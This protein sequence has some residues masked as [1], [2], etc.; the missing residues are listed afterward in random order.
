ME[1]EINLNLNPVAIN[2]TTTVFRKVMTRNR[3][4]SKHNSSSSSST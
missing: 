3:R 2:H 1:S 4:N